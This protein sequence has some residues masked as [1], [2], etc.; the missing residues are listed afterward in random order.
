MNLEQ[1]R[2]EIE[3]VQARLDARPGEPVAPRH[4]R[5]RWAAELAREYRREFHPLEAA[6]EPAPT[7]VEVDPTAAEGAAA[8]FF[9][10][11][12]AAWR[13]GLFL[14]PAVRFISAHS[15]PILKVAAV[16][17][18]IVGAAGFLAQW[19]RSGGG[20][21]AALDAPARATT[22]APRPAWVEIQKPF[23]LFDLAAPQL[24]REKRLYTARRHNTGGGREDVLTF[25]EF[26][27]TGPFLRVS[28][29]RHGSE[30]SADAAYFVDMARR[31]A[32]L[33]LS[34]GRANNAE[35]QATRFGDVETAA[36]TLTEGRVARDNCRGFRFS[37]AQ[38]GL[39]LAGFACG[40]GQ[41]AVSG[42][43][44]ACLLD[45]LDLVSAGEDRAL[46]DFF[47]AAQARGR[48]AAPNRFPRRRKSRRRGCNKTAPADFFNLARQIA[49]ARRRKALNCGQHQEPIMRR[50]S[51]IRPRA[52]VRRACLRQRPGR[53]Q[54]E[55]PP[56]GRHGRQSRG[57]HRPEEDL[58]RAGQCGPVGTQDRYAQTVKY[59]SNP[60]PGGTYRNDNFGDWLLP[61]WFGG[62]PGFPS[63]EVP[64][65][66][67]ALKKNGRAKA[68]PF[69]LTGLAAQ[70]LA[71]ST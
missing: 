38:L 2:R 51:L 24:A 11:G 49:I 29:Y 46:R 62:V 70:S 17:L 23:R 37:A 64:S 43:D 39:T 42:G 53:G 21:E 69:W 32:Q 5:E 68:R 4:S 56:V 12:K 9:V 18:A 34:L 57:T 31:A 71:R 35:T 28:V 60:A 59:P 48:A 6:S 1:S 16:D 58:A 14:E 22:A 45:R 67:A 15:A 36:L 19:P 27:G 44:L 30:K 52:R 61:Q 3:A 50:Q 65:L 54:A 47:A 25:G 10:A 40:A 63:A 26:A 55:N 41:E 7:A 13:V 33:G 20:D 66:G 8:A